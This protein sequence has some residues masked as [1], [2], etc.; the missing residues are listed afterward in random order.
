[1]GKS[2]FISIILI[3]AISIFAVAQEISIDFRYNVCIPEPSRNYLNWSIGSR[4]IRDSLDTTTGASRARSTRELDAFRYD[5]NGRYTIPVGLRQ[6]LLFPVTPEKYLRFW[7]LTVLEEGQKL[8]IRFIIGN[9]LYQIRT[10]DKKQFD[11]RNAFFKAPEIAE[12]G[13]LSPLVLRPQYIL[14][15]GN[16]RDWNSLDLS[17]VQWRPD[18]A[19]ASASRKYTGVLTAGYAGGVL[20]ITGRLIP[21]R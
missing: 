5:S 18:I 6:L 9:T 11:V 20:T 8:V 1:M 12:T 17:K 14:P 10:D 4:N 16:A 21:E 2:F 13:S 15:G 3:F 7:P 19:D